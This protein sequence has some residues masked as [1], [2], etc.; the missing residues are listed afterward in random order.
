[1]SKE[2]RYPQKLIDYLTEQE[3]EFNAEIFMVRSH[4]HEAVSWYVVPENLG[5]WIIIVQWDGYSDDFQLINITG[6]A[7]DRLEKVI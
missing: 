2:Y 6:K 5:N 4:D 1:M 3:F 7:I